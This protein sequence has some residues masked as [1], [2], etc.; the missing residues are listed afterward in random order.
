[1]SKGALFLALG[2]LAVCSPIVA[3][4]AKHSGA[5]QHR[6]AA[7]AIRPLDAVS[8]LSIYRPNVVNASDSILFHNGP[9]RAWSDGAQL[10]SES[11]FVQIGMAPLGLFPV[12]YLAPSDVGPAPIRNP[13]AA[14]Y[15]RSASLPT[16]GKDLPAEMLNSPLNQVYVTGEIGF[17]YGQWS[18]KGSGDYVGSY[19]WGQAGNDKLQITAG[20]SF[21][22]WNGSGPKFRSLNFAR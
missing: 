19:I 10:V 17:M 1:M 2:F 3:Q 7:S 9:V 8:N 18:G 21:E 14:S 16:D 20:G 4:Q 15:S 12:S 13:S 22:N 11:A 6:L 5:A